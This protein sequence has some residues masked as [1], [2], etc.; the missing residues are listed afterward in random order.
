MIVQYRH[1]KQ[2]S[3]EGLAQNCSLRLQ[4]PPLLSCKRRILNAKLLRSRCKHRKKSAVATYCW[5]EKTIL[6]CCTDWFALHFWCILMTCFVFQFCYCY[7]ISSSFLLSSWCTVLFSVSAPLLV[8]LALLCVLK[9][10][11][12]NCPWK[13]TGLSTHFSIILSLAL[14]IKFSSN[15]WRFVVPSSQALCSDSQTRGPQ[16]SIDCS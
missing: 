11:T 12:G 2:S 7:L 6:F 15:L 14:H 9:K 8:K 4:I 13:G 1:T 3:L 16:H 5:F 10:Q